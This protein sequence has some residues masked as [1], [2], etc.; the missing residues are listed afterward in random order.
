[1]NVRIFMNEHVYPAE[2]VHAAQREALT[3]A[4]LPHDVPE[5][6]QGLIGLARERSLGFPSAGRVNIIPLGRS[7]SVPEQIVRMR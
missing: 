6:L 7:G 1:M 5:V 2:K 3:S 4:D